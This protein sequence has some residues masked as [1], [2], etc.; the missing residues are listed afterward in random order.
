MLSS[1]QSSGH[2]MG[3][4][5]QAVGPRRRM[6]RR[7]PWSTPRVAAARS[8]NQQAKA[9]ATAG[10][11]E[12]GSGGSERGPRDVRTGELRTRDHPTRPGTDCAVGSGQWAEPPHP[13]WALHRR[14]VRR[15]T[16]WGP[17]RA[18]L[19]RAP[20]GSSARSGLSPDLSGG[21]QTGRA[22]VLGGGTKPP[23]T[24]PAC[25]LDGRS[26]PHRAYEQ[27]GGGHVPG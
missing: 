8:T 10:P 2:G 11:A 27:C 13:P 3:R 18:P 26:R 14:G 12:R 4:Q 19:R 22:G 21:Q 16:F 23:Q 25:S 9:G 15:S 17:P 1:D 24:P 20:R 6:A 5:S 7:P